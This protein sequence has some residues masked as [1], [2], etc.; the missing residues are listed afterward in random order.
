M[1]TNSGTI[2]VVLSEFEPWSLWMGPVKFTTRL[3]FQFF[4]LWVVAPWRLRNLGIFQR[5][6]SRDCT[7]QWPTVRVIFITIWFSDC[8][9]ISRGEV[10]LRILHEG[11]PRPLVYQRI[12]ACMSSYR[13]CSWQI[14]AKMLLNLL[15]CLWSNC[16]NR[17]WQSGSDWLS[18]K[19]QA[20][21]FATT[22]RTQPAD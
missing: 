14:S 19:R 8:L 18:A 11:I 13:F 21:L 12:H 5:S 22:H 7:V 15:F 16:M 6:V 3:R 17:D 10:Q 20:F 9:W 4:I 1:F 2:H